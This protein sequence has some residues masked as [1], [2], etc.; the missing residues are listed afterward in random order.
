MFHEMFHEI[1]QFPLIVQRIGALNNRP[2]YC[3]WQNGRVGLE[4]PGRQLFDLQLAQRRYAFA[5]FCDGR[6][7]D[8]QS[9]SDSRLTAEMLY[10]VGSTHGIKIRRA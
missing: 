4:F 7:L 3:A 5:P 6:G 9:A 1:C 2:V 8:I 10:N